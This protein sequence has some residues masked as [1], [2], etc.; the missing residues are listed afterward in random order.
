MALTSEQIELLDQ[1]LV[2]GFA[3]KTIPILGGKAEITFNSMTAANQLEVESYMKN[4][5]GAPAFV[6]HTYSIKLLARV[7]VKYHVVGKDPVLFTSP[8]EAEAFL[9]GRPSTVVDAII[10]AQGEFEKTL[11]ELAKTEDLE[12]NFTQTPSPDSAPTS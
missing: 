5:E 10:S 3:T 11:G 2:K 6:V 8:E 12:V 9:R 7:L 1:I 4:I